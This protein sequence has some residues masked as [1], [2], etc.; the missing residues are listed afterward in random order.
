[1]SSD[2]RLISWADELDSV[3]NEFK[4][5]VNLIEKCTKLESSEL[6][7]YFN[8]ETKEGNQYTVSLS[9]SGFQIVSNNFECLESTESRGEALN[10]FESFSSLLNSISPQYKTLFSNQLIDELSKLE[11]K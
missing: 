7:R 9:F 11:K 4:K 1:M 2:C 10:K 6:I 8:L 5:F 3:I